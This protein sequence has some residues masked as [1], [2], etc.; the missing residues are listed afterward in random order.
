MAIKA[1]KMEIAVLSP[2][3]APEIKEV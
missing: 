1:G 2:D 3:S